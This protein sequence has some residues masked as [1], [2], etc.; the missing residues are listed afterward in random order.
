MAEA[1]CL[2]DA[3]FQNLQAQQIMLGNNS[4]RVAGFVSLNSGATAAVTVP[5]TSLTANSVHIIGGDGAAAGAAAGGAVSVTLPSGTAVPNVGDF[6]TFLIGA[7]SINTGHRI[8][9]GD[10]TNDKLVGGLQY[11]RVPNTGEIVGAAQNAVYITPN[12]STTT[13]HRIVLDAD[14][15]NSGGVEG[16]WIT[17]TYIG[18]PWTTNGSEH[19]WYISGQ[20]ISDDVDGDGTAVFIA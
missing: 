6:Y 12:Q 1:G 9:L 11:I 14:L 17:F 15:D 4:L 20:V 10:T 16:T 19:T 3:N 8:I 5:A 18:T 7:K 13:D 2:R